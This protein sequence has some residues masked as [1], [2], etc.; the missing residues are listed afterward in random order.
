MLHVYN[1]TIFSICKELFIAKFDKWLLDCYN[2]QPNTN[3]L[4]CFIYYIEKILNV[5]GVILEILY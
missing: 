4:K 2:S 5:I 3:Y 1:N